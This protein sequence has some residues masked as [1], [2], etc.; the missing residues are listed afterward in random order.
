MYF[1]LSLLHTVNLLFVVDKLICHIIHRYYKSYIIVIHNY[2]TSLL[3][4]VII[5]SYYTSLLIKILCLLCRR[6]GV[7]RCFILIFF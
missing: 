7:K 5:H 1:N 4:I 2:Y 6:L 3:Y